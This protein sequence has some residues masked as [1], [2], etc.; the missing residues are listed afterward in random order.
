MINF[1]NT[2][3]IVSIPK[4]YNLV[5]DFAKEINAFEFYDKHDLDTSKYSVD[6]IVLYST[7]LY[8]EKNVFNLCSTAY[9]Y[10]EQPIKLISWFKSEITKYA[11]KDR[12][13]IVDFTIRILQDKDRF[14][15]DETILMIGLND[16]DLNNDY[17]LINQHEFQYFLNSDTFSDYELFVK[18]ILQIKGILQTKK[19]GIE[20]FIKKHSGSND[21][22]E[23]VSKYCIS[24]DETNNQIKSF[25]FSNSKY[26]DNLENT[27]DRLKPDFIHKTTTLKQFKKVFSNSEISAKVKWEK[28]PASLHYFI[29]ELMNKRIIKKEVIGKWNVAD[30]CFTGKTEKDKPFDANTIQ[31]NKKPNI[32]DKKQL[33]TI[34]N[35]LS[36][37]TTSTTSTTK[38]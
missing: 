8:M 28:S 33:D 1:D 29:D 17:K 25:E 35:I 20:N 34:I 13:A 31:N 10:R 21:F 32:I 11:I 4:N 15:F 12:K 24:K 9:R 18:S 37:N 16:I 36:K 3:W 2:K 22:N 30:Y 38:K 5:N 7:Y 23:I 19:Q 14:P 6:E 26:L 27:F